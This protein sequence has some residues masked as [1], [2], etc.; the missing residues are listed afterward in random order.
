MDVSGRPQNSAKQRIGEL[1][2]LPV[3]FDL[4]G[5]PVLV[6][7]ESDGAAWKA[8]LLASCG[9]EVH[10][11]A[12]LEQA[13]DA[14][15]AFARRDGVVH[16]DCG[17]DATYFKHFALAVGDCPPEE[18]RAFHDRAREAGVPV[19][20]NSPNSASSSSAASSIAR[21]W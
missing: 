16:H 9:A 12:R 8:E 3:F 18:G 20:V 1:A 2:T 4:N 14:I 11:F 10:L 19:N 6:A 7:G 17:W 15:R 21:R 5:K 13:G